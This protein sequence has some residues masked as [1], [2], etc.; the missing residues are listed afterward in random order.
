MHQQIHPEY[1]H[2]NHSKQ[3]VWQKSPANNLRK[4][5]IWLAEKIRRTNQV[6]YTKYHKAKKLKRIN[7][8]TAKLQYE[9][10]EPS[11]NVK[12]FVG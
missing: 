1:K 12:P 8:A 5:K 9:A 7:M 6:A 11:S 4:N 2:T 3:S 10:M